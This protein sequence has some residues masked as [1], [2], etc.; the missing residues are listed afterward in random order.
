M[1]RIHYADVISLGFKEEISRDPVYFEKY[2][3]EYSIISKKV[4]KR[5]ILHWTKNNGKCHLVYLGN[6]H[7]VLRVKKLKSLEEVKRIIKKYNE[8]KK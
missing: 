5:R 1:A 3:F 6:D 8:R 4:A 7:L 2:G